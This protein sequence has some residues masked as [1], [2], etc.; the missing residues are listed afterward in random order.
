MVR[1][2]GY[3]MG[4]GTVVWYVRLGTVWSTERWYGTYIA[5]GWLNIRNSPSEDPLEYLLNLD[6]F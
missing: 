6:K 4:Y 2:V 1:T 3:G 5:V